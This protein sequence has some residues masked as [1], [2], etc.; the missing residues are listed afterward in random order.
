MPTTPRKVSPDSS[1]VLACGQEE[2]GGEDNDAGLEL[3]IGQGLV[4]VCK[5]T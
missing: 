4:T 5:C 3:G 2:S 1:A